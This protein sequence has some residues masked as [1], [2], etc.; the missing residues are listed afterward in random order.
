MFEGAQNQPLVFYT[1]KWDYNTFSP[2][3]FINCFIFINSYYYKIII[4]RN[5]N[6]SS[7]LLPLFPIFLTDTENTFCLFCC[8]TSPAPA[9][10]R[11][12]LLLDGL[13]GFS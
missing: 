10:M 11:V 6:T 12:Q 1:V 8:T 2:V 7:L 13:S 5:V 9:P 3:I 4:A